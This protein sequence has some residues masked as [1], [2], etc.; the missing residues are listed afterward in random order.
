MRLC[1]SVVLLLS[2]G[3]T[4]VTFQMVPTPAPTLPPSVEE[5][6][7]YCNAEGDLIDEEEQRRQCIVLWQ[8]KEHKLEEQCEEY[9][10]EK[11]GVK[12]EW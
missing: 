11:I 8:L 7:D 12:N 9:C 6:V 5:Y 1:K 2:M 4:T 3:C 10:T